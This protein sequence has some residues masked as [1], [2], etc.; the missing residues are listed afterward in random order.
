MPPGDIRDV[1][2]H[3][4]GLGCPHTKQTM[5]VFQ[6]IAYFLATNHTEQ[7]MVV[8]SCLIATNYTEKKSQ[9]LD[10]WFFTSKHS[11][12]ALQQSNH[13]VMAG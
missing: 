10:S 7:T 13:G 11:N 9:V 4:D 3:P 2:P 5:V 6:F 1:H 12:K 8:F